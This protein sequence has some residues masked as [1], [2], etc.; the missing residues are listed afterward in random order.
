MA[1]V[2]AEGCSGV[3]PPTYCPDCLALCG[4]QLD[5]KHPWGA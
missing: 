4:G 1:D 5:L 3:L 2:L